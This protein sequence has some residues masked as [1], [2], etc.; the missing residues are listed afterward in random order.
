M[1]GGRFGI[2]GLKKWINEW[3]RR[4]KNEALT[5]TGTNLIGKDRY[6][7]CGTNDAFA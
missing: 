4:G 3:T 5:E 1:Y 2:R 6:S 7:D